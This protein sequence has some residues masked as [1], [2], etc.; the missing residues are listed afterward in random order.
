MLMGTVPYHVSK[1]GKNIVLGQ[2]GSGQEGS[3]HLLEMVNSER[4][5]N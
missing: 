4:Q 3:G 1:Y 5:K 2:E